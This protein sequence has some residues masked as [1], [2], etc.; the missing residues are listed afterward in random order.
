VLAKSTN[1]T[2][3]S[4]LTTP[5]GPYYKVSLDTDVEYFINGADYTSQ[6]IA[7]DSS[8]IYYTF[9]AYQAAGNTTYT[10][11]AAFITAQ[12]ALHSADAETASDKSGVVVSFINTDIDA[13][14]E[15]VVIVEKQVDFVTGNITVTGGTVNIPGVGSSYSV[16]AVKYPADLAKNDVVLLYTD[17]LGVTHIEKAASVTGRMTAR[18]YV[19]SASA[20]VF[21]GVTRA[22]SELTGKASLASFTT[23][24]KDATI[25]LDD[26]GNVV[27]FLVGDTAVTSNYLVL[28]QSKESGFD[29]IAKVLFMDGSTKTVTLGSVNGS[30]PTAPATTNKFYTYAVDSDGY[31]H[32]ATVTSSGSVALDSQTDTTIT[33]VAK[34]DGSNL[35]NSSTIFVVPND[36]INGGTGYTVFTGVANAPL[37]SATDFEVISINGIAKFVYVYDGTYTATPVTNRAY[38]INSAVY[39]SY[40]RTAANP[41]YREYAAIVDGQAT[42]VKVLETAAGSITTGLMTVQ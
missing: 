15:K 27:H 22:E 6:G 2:P 8:G 13:K 18:T 3:I 14:A 25:W 16:D 36:L 28:L 11:E 7:G 9:A 12:K 42:K 24:N 41:A 33:N 19:G 21:D 31:Y 5:Y 38:I 39:T 1:G 34:F 17:A 37:F 30:A 20:I 4:A 23:Y 10:T 40:P 32:L 35:G 26:N 29:V